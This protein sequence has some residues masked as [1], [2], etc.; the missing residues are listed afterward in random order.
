MCDAWDDF[1]SNSQHVSRRTTTP[2]LQHTASPISTMT[3]SRTRPNFSTHTYKR[4]LSLALFLM[5]V[6]ILLPGYNL[7]MVLPQSFSSSL[8]KV[9]LSTSICHTVA[10]PVPPYSFWA[11]SQNGKQLALCACDGI[12]ILSF[13][14]RTMIPYYIS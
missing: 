2:E 13:L 5:R 14:S 3:I 4:I 1:F 7:S 10:H 8:I 6:T 12:S 9:H 11:S